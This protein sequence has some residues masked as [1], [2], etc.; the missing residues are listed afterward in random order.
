[1]L[2]DDKKK[3][4]EALS[5]DEM[6]QKINLGR[7]SRFQREAFAYLKTC[8]EARLREVNSIQYPATNPSDNE[9]PRTGEN[10]NTI[11]IWHRPIGAIWIIVAGGIILAFAIYLFR[12]HLG[13]PL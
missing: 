10:Q 11:N 1:M 13:I 9:P 3:R 8:Y 7:E 6:A 5:V 4:I 12:T 2:S